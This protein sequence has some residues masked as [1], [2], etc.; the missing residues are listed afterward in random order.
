MKRSVSL[1]SGG[2]VIVLLVGAFVLVKSL[3]KKAAAVAPLITISNVDKAKIDEITL[4]HGGQKVQIKQVDKKFVVQY[5]YNVKWD[6]SSV[7]QVVSSFTSLNADRE[8]TKNPT[9]LAQFGLSPAKGVAV[10]TLAGGEKVQIDI[11]NKTPTGTDYYVMKQGDPALYAAATYGVDPLLSSYD[12]LRDKTLPSIN[13]QKL[14][15]FEVS[16]NGQTIE[17]VPM[18]KGSPLANVSFSSF[19]I[20]QPYPV[21][22]AAAADKLSTLLKSFPSY[23]LAQKYINDRPTQGQ[24][25]QYGLSPAK[26]HIV[27]KDDTNTLDIYLGNQLPDGTMYARLAGDPSVFTVNYSDFKPLLDANLFDLTDKF[28][29]IPNI[30]DVASFTIKT[31]TASYDAKIVT[32]TEPAAKSGSSGSSSASTKSTYY[33]NGKTVKESDFKNFYQAVI[34]LLADA[35]N[36]NPHIAFNPEITITF[37]LTK[38]TP[39][40]YSEYLVPYNNL[41]YAV[42]RDGYADMLLDKGQVKTMLTDAQDLLSGKPLASP[43]G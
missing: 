1:I 4:D 35:A 14:T 39:D 33:L 25:A 3:P 27:L 19:E 20:V 17:I 12:S 30:A 32:T 34:G 18:P 42:Y 2:I 7:A 28:L 10:A 11:G 6:S 16:N 22:R 36:P 38:G 26:A 37:H 41:F 29:L 13:T 24:L 23:L 21:P 15:Y 9:D 8:L 5:P 40:V 43:N 31:P